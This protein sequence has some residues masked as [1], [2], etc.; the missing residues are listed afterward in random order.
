MVFSRAWAARSAAEIRLA[1]VSRSPARVSAAVAVSLATGAGLSWTGAPRS[2]SRWVR[3]WSSRTAAWVTA[4]TC[5]GLAA[6]AGTTGAAKVE[7]FLGMAAHRPHQPDRP[8]SMAT[9]AASALAARGPLL[10]RAPRS[11]FKWIVSMVEEE[12]AAPSTALPKLELCMGGTEQTRRA[13]ARPRPI[14]LSIAQP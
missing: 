13:G 9:G 5:C 10:R 2:T 4:A 6:L 12:A 1:S 11:P 3:A 14:S 7:A 8:T